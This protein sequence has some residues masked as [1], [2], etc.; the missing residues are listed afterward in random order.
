MDW[1]TYLT[2]LNGHCEEF[3][4]LSERNGRSMGGFKQRYHLYFQRILQTTVHKMD[5]MRRG[6]KWDQ[7]GGC[8][9]KKER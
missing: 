7:I 9:G 1:R 5:Y 3:G 4:F 6:W 2:G 8:H